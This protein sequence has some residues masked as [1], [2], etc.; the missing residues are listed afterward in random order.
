MELC[1]AVAIERFIAEGAEHLHFGFTP[2]LF[3]GRDGP[4]ASPTLAFMLRVLARWGQAIYPAR[5]QVDY[6]L[7]WGPEIV[8][9][10]YVACRPLS[11]RG[12]VDLLV[13]TRSV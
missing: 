3:D 10:E 7:K 5:S 13:L 11:L 2:F 9:T 4:G 6:K 1:N 12:I 8:E